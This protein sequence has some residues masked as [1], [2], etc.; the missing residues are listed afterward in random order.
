MLFLEIKRISF[1]SKFLLAL[2]E[3]QLAAPNALV[4]ISYSVWSHSLDRCLKVLGFT[5]LTG[6]AVFSGCVAYKSAVFCSS[7]S[8][9]LSGGILVSFAYACFLAKSFSFHFFP[10]FSSFCFFFF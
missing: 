2:L 4:Q 7:G 9:I 8:S 10:S 6:F 3:V 1:K 5:L